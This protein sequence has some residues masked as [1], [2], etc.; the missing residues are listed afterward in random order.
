MEAGEPAEVDPCE[1]CGRTDRPMTTQG[2]AVCYQL[3]V[4]CEAIAR[5]EQGEGEASRG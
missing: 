3:C 2:T 5:R 4:R 1:S